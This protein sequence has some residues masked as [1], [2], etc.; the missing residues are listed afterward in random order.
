MIRTRR[1]CCVLLAKVG[2]RIGADRRSELAA[3]LYNL[4]SFTSALYNSPHSTCGFVITFGV[5]STL[6]TGPGWDPATGL[7]TP[8]PRNLVHAFGGD[9]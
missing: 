3:P 8:N 4:T 6:G 7:G 5:D 2:P 9:D 1:R